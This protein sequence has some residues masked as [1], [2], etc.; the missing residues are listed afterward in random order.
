MQPVSKF[1]AELR[2]LTL[3]PEV[4][5]LTRG[6]RASL[7]SHQLVQD[8]EV[9]KLYR[10]KGLG[11]KD[12]IFAKGKQPLFVR[13]DATISCVIALSQPI[14]IDLFSRS[15]KLGQ[16]TL[17]ESETGCFIAFGRVVQ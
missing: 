2:I 13:S 7:C 8:C 17:R 5:I 10:A 16:F 6:F 11:A 9:S 12:I 4:P 15:H 1:K 3:P 14:A